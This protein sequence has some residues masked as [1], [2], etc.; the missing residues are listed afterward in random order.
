MSKSEYLNG[1]QKYFLRKLRE[2]R[3]GLPLEDWP[4]TST[5]RRWMR[6]SKFRAAMDGMED[7]LATEKRLLMSGAGGVRDADHALGQRPGALRSG[8]QSK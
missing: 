8:D 4:R 3:H 6:N 2:H 5:W 1:H 7:A